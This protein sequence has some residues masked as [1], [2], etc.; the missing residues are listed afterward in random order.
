[1]Y[2]YTVNFGVK[3]AFVRNLIEASI[4]AGMIAIA[5]ALMV[6]IET[7]VNDTTVALI[8]ILLIVVVATFLEWV[9]ATAS[10]LL[11][12]FAFNFFFLDPHY[13]LNIDDPE[14][15]VSL[16]V[17]LAVGITIGHISATSNRRRAEAERLYKDMEQAFEKASEAEGIKRSEKLKGALLD[18]VTHDF[19]TPL[20]SIK[21]S[22]TMLIEENEFA[23]KDKKLDHHSRGELLNVIEQ[24]SDRLNTFVE[25]MVELARFQSG[26]SELKL[27]SVTAEE[28]IVK[29]AKRAKEI[30]RSHRLVSSIGPDLSPMLLDP[31]FIVEAVFNL[32]DNAAKYSAA[33]SKIEITAKPS[34]GKIR[35]SVED[36]GPGIPPEDREEVFKKFYQRDLHKD[37]G[38]GMGLAI[39]RG[40]IEAHG[41][42][43]WVEPG[44]KGAK[45]VFD[46]PTSGNGT[47]AKDP[48]GR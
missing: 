17:F 26:S 43:I 44:K 31:R 36:E 8:Y 41:G 3:S 29:A 48:G 18:A 22:V 21:A 35:F 40:I 32:I 23:S 39:V 13:T 19:R 38:M 33:H 11:A 42:E 15:W 10:S 30:Q 47:E 46:L 7:S 25:S 34:D 9:A 37:R 20:T 27:S 14:N 28:I 1:V 6:Q 2:S 24:E 12:S 45:F 16:F 5:T 4:A